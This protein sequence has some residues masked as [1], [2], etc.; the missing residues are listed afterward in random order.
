MD[1]VYAY[2]RFYRHSSVIA[3]F[4]L[5][6]CSHVLHFVYASWVYF[7]MQMMGAL[8]RYRARVICFFWGLIMTLQVL[9]LL[10]VRPGVT[11]RPT[12]TPLLHQNGRRPFCGLHS[13]LGV[14]CYT[15]WISS[16]RGCGPVH[17]FPLLGSS[18]HGTWFVEL[19]HFTAL[20]NACLWGLF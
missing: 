15:L 4:Q 3:R 13:P 17:V 6:S 2:V 7:Y 5:C 8:W 12:L 9:I 14:L 19:G 10:P 20:H 1:Y 18:P 11:P 16:L